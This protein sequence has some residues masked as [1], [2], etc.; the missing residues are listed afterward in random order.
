MSPFLSSRWNNKEHLLDCL[1]HLQ[2]QTFDKFEVVLVD[3]GSG[4]WRVSGWIA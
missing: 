3:N 4:G 2:N 1:E